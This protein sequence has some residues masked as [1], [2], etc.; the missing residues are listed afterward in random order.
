MSAVCQ[1]PGSLLYS[2]RLTIEEEDAL[3]LLRF[4]MSRLILAR[5]RRRC[6]ASKSHIESARGGSMSSQEG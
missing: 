5:F 2:G 3:V 4:D 6:P 1:H